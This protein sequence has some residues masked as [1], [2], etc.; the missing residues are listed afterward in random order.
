M[1]VV[2]LPILGAVSLVTLQILGILPA[3]LQPVVGIAGAWAI[4]GIRLLIE[5]RRRGVS[6]P[7]PRGVIVWFGGLSILVIVGG[8]LFWTGAN[9][10]SSDTGATMFMAGTFLLAL[11]GAAPFF[12]VFDMFLRLIGRSLRKLAGGIAGSPKQVA[13]RP[14]PEQALATAEMRP[15]R[16]QAG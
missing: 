7:A 10:L 14:V 6:I 15:V 4:F 2:Y 1:W 11:A 5:R 16:R 13:Q 12:K 8:I 9:R 3:M